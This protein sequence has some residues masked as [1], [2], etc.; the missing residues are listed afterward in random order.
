VRV[1][2]CLCARP[3][4]VIPGKAAFSRYQAKITWTGPTARLM[5]KPPRRHPLGAGAKLGFR[6]RTRHACCM[7]VSVQAGVRQTAIRSLRERL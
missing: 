3:W 4:E 2:S 1:S 6:T 5:R 7:R